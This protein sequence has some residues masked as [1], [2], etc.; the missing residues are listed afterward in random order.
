MIG[1]GNGNGNGISFINFV[2]M[3]VGYKIDLMAKNIN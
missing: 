2:L 3:N 1:N